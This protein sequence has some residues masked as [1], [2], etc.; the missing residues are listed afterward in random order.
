MEGTKTAKKPTAAQLQRRIS[1][2]VLHIDRTKDTKELYFSDKGLR[3]TLADDFVIIATGYHRH[4][5]NNVT[6]QGYSRP[7]MYSERVVNIA[8][9]NDCTIKDEYGDT[10]RSFTKL[11]S[12]LKGK[13]DQTDYNIVWYYDLWLMN[14]FA[15]LYTIDETLVGAFMVYEQYI[16]NIARNAFLLKE[17]KEDVTN[18]QFANNIIEGEKEFL[19][20]LDE[21]VV[22]T[23]KTDEERINEEIAALQE[24]EQEDD[25]LTE[26]EKENE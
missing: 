19:A 22:L 11:M 12:I 26:L 23:A 8:L 24:Q 15:P 5:F 7:Y 14:I 2:A 16:H 25:M 3:I 10:T 21:V 1:S 18:I 4:V 13:D 20:N 17:H 9:E 6:T